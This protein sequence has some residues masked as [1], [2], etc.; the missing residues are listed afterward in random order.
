MNLNNIIY[1]ECFPKLDLHGLD[2]NCALLY[3]KDF[4]ND[5]IKLKNE[6]ITI[7]HGNG[8]KI[9]KETTHNYLKSDKRIED[10]KTFYFNDGCT[11][12]KLKI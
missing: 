2:R 6:I 9:L 12:V 4:I 10:F 8:Q 11:V 7:I 3:I 5:N 1:L